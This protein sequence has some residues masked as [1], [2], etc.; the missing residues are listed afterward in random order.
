MGCSN[1]NTIEANNSQNTYFQTNDNIR[2]LS[3]RVGNDSFDYK[4]PQK[5]TTKTTYYQV[6]QNIISGSK[7]RIDI[8]SII[9]KEK[10]KQL[11]SKLP[12]RETTNLSSFKETIKNL[13]IN[14]N[15]QEKAFILFLWIGQNINYDAESYFLNL[16]VD[17]TPEGVFENGSTVCSGYSRLYRDIG[18]YIGLTIENVTCYA[19]G[20]GYNPGDKFTST[21]HEYNVIKFNDI[22]YPIDSTWG[23]GHIKDR[24]YVREFN[25]FYFCC[26][27]EYLIRTH[28]PSEEKW[29]LTEKKYTLDEF[30]NWVKIYSHF[31]TLGFYKCIPDN[32]VININNNGIN[33][34]QKFIIWNR[35]MKN[36]KAS[37]TVNL[38]IDNCYY[39]QS[40]LNFIFYYDDKIKVPCIFNKKGIYRIVIFATN[41]I[42]DPRTHSMCDYFVEVENDAE[43]EL[44]Y[45]SVYSQILARKIFL[46]EPIYGILRHGE[47]VK[48]KLKSDLDTIAI[49]DN[50]N[51]I[52]L[53]KNNEGFFEKEITIQ[54]KPGE[55][56]PLITKGKNSAPGILEY[57]V[58]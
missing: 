55:N 8:K 38:L 39:Q 20:V 50:N 30:S 15:P 54:T 37:C 19:K 17:V 23:A 2:I 46:I 33:N 14:L 40:N 42:N 47:K 49:K 27:P 52:F 4:P 3:I 6:S 45:P 11:T 34:Y 1:T 24:H 18:V 10:C 41:D 43:K 53:E 5:N 12:K 36:Y 22:W 26:E 32:C 28:F 29:M 35:N 48:F 13:T 16:N 7:N 57:Q 44:Y 31:Y 21:D 25:E 51:W 56:I 9:D 58:A